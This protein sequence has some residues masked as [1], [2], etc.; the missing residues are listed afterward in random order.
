MSRT[1]VWGPPSCGSEKSDWENVVLKSLELN[2]MSGDTGFQ[3][4]ES[5]VKELVMIAATT[6]TPETVMELMMW[7]LARMVMCVA[8][9][10]G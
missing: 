1:G 10:V 5:K 2:E 7:N 6:I 9:W 3:T 8:D 4:R